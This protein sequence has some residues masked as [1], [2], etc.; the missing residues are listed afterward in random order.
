MHAM[1]GLPKFLL[2]V[3]AALS[4]GLHALAKE[5]PPAKPEDVGMSST[6]VDEVMLDYVA[7]KKLAGA[8][9][10]VARK[11]KVVHFG[12]YGKMDLA[13]DKEMTD[14][15][16]FRIYSMSKAIT[17]A[18]ALTLLEEGKYSLD[19]PVSK[20]I[21][22]FK[23][24]T[25]WKNGKAVPAKK[26]MTV[27]HLMLHTAGLSYGF[28]G[29]GPVERLYKKKKPTDRDGTLPGMI[30]T[31][32]DIPLAFEPGTKWQYS[33][34]IDVL[35][36]LIEV[37]SGKKFEDFL[38][39]RIFKPL[40]MKDTAFHVPAD[41]AGRLTA[42]YGL[43][44]PGKLRLI[45]DPAKSRYLEPASLPSGGGGLVSTTR[46][47]YLRF[48]QTILNGGELHGTR[49]LKKKTVRLMTRNQLPKKLMPIQIGQPPRTGVGFGLGFNVRVAMSDWDSGGKV[50]EIGWGG[51]ASTHYWASPKDDLLVVTM[52]QIMPYT[53]ATEWAVK[54]LIYDAIEN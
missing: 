16:I 10:A 43:G 15:A 7:K 12:T 14:D 21:P 53:F 3:L 23:D 1:K 13:G 26:A 40:D 8:I 25:V 28:I 39:E 45:D 32:S 34:S 4:T 6:K 30:K 11:G 50:G 31:L 51:A 5:L 37:W 18:A 54:K 42:S 20:Y 35:G 46:D 41:K 52:E 19:D 38:G 49:I 33:A 22:E 48:L 47:D 44:D 2:L 36:R 27:K 29:N 17:T 9:V 24:L